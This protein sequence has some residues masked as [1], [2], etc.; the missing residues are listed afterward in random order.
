ML[1][2]AAEPKFH[3]YYYY[4]FL[5]FNHRS[6]VACGAPQHRPGAAWGPGAHAWAG[7]AGARGMRGCSRSC[8]GLGA[9]RTIVMA[10]R[11]RSH[12]ALIP[13]GDLKVRSLLLPVSACHG[14]AHRAWHRARAEAGQEPGSVR[15]EGAPASTS[16]SPGLLPS[17]LHT[18]GLL[19]SQAGPHKTWAVVLRA[20]AALLP[21]VLC[22]STQGIHPSRLRE[23]EVHGPNARGW[24]HVRPSPPEMLSATLLDTLPAWPGAAFG[25][26]GVSCKAGGS[27]CWP[28]WR[29]R[30]WW[31]CGVMGPS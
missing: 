29:E 1:P 10:A 18:S 25:C 16:A 3:F 17:H 11:R 5:N 2:A 31:L 27:L 30:P 19:R 23:T 13:R 24:C 26:E 12:A 8:C 15:R 22:S 7:G 4:F 21:P 14:S 28:C 9:C 20:P 6:E